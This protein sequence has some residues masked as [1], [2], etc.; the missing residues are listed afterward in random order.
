M[1]AGFGDKP[2]VTHKLVLL[3]DM[4]VGKTCMAI[5]YY[6]GEYSTATEPTIGGC[7]LT[8]D[9]ELDTHIV[10]FEIWDTAG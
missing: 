7:F 1:A 9:C 8:K 10:S 3:G 2:K 6:K 5:R 4:G